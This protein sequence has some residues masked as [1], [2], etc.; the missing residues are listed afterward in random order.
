ML[1]FSEYQILSFDCYGTLIDWELG[2]TN[3]MLPFLRSHGVE[4][5]AETVLTRYAQFESQI[6]A[7][8]FLP[9]RDVLRAVMINF[10]KELSFE[11]NDLEQDTLVNSIGNWP[12]FDDTVEA[13]RKL[14]QRYK[15]AIIS[16]VDADLFE[17]TTRHLVVKFNYV[18]TASQVGAYKPDKRMFEAAAK[19]FGPLKK[20]WLHVAQSLYHDIAPANE[21]GLSSVWINRRGDR[22]GSGATP[23][24]MAKPEAEFRSLAEFAEAATFVG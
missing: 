13:L 12:V 9:Y 15:L 22:A 16:N 19:A 6:E 23:L 18:V 4:M 10:S 3:A 24:V 5:N 21:F 8:G 7:G 20:H 11:L 17:E 14:K 1:D 2:I